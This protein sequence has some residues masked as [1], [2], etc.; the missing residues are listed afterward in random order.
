MGIFNVDSSHWWNLG[1]NKCDKDCRNVWSLLQFLEKFRWNNI[2]LDI[3]WKSN[4]IVLFITLK[5][6]PVKWAYPLNFKPVTAIKRDVIIKMRIVQFL[7][8]FLI[9]LTFLVPA[10]LSWTLIGNGDHMRHQLKEVAQVSPP[11]KCGNNWK[12]ESRD[13]IW[14]SG[15]KTLTSW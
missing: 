11:D 5:M 8:K 6:V 2:P 7:L 1:Y 13:S 10:S 12:R 4:D 9:A 15:A 14:H 3:Y